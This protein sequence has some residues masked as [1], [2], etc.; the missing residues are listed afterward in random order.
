MTFSK[1]KIFKY[2]FFLLN[3]LHSLC[4][5]IGAMTIDQMALPGIKS[6][7]VANESFLDFIMEQQ[8]L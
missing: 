6:A 8:V 3:L 5:S 1:R 7:K 2:L 4:Q